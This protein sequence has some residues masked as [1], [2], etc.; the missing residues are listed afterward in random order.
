VANNNMPI[1][2]NSISDELLALLADMTPNQIRFIV[3]AQ[4]YQTFKEA[5]EAIN[6][7][8]DTVYRWPQEIKRA[9]ELFAK[10]AAAGALAIRR[11]YLSKAMAVKVAGLDDEDG[12]LRQSVATEIIEWELGK[13]TQKQELTGEDGQ[14]IAITTIEV[15]RDSERNA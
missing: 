3:A 4:D 8:P 2:E 7:K 10:D 9:V 12:R 11:R 1:T 15:I 14:P 13:A 6:L 5:A